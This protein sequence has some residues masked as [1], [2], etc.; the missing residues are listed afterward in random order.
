M[1]TAIIEQILELK[2]EAINAGFDFPT[3]DPENATVEELEAFLEELKVFLETE[4]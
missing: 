2:N 4:K 1:K 3:E